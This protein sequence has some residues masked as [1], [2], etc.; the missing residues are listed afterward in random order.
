VWV[1]TAEARSIAQHLDELVAA[2]R[3]RS[4]AG[5]YALA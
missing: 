5:R 4:E 3:V 2:G 1:T